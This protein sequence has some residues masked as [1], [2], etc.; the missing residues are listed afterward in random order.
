M[1]DDFNLETFEFY[2]DR[3]PFILNSILNY[4]TNGELHLSDN[5]CVD[6]YFKELEY[7]GHS[8]DEFKECCIS[9]YWKKC[10]EINNS[11]KLERKVIENYTKENDFGNCLPKM[12]E[13]IWKILN[14]KDTTKASK[15]TCFT[16][17]VLVL[18]I[19]NHDLYFITLITF[20]FLKGVLRVCN[21]YFFVI[22]Y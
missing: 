21:I 6:L 14:F 20:N 19:K 17:H 12:K 3:D 10:N 16:I 11:I 18:E 5:V 8:E 9:K 15:V 2:F 4:Y 7:W 13:K 22:N 1:C